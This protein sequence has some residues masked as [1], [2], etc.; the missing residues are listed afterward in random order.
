M[1]FQTPA[2]NPDAVSSFFLLDQLQSD[3]SPSTCLFLKWEEPNCN[4]ADITSY[5]I[6]LDDQLITVDTGTSH[7]ITDLQPDSQYSVQIHR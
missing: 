3:Q 7:L 1:T 6:S 5:I 2:T 4:G